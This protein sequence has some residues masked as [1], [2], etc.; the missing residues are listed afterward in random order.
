MGNQRDGPIAV[1]SNP[2]GVAI[3]PDGG[4]AY[5]ANIFGSSV[6]VIAIEVA[7][8]LTGTPASGV[9]GQ[10]YSHTFTTSGQPDPTITVTAGTL[11]AG[12]TRTPPTPNNTPRHQRVTP[13]AFPHPRTVNRSTRPIQLPPALPSNESPRRA[14]TITTANTE[15][16]H[17]QGRIT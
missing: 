6:S 1:G 15:K 5:V 9:L 13:P 16:R 7:P 10:P 2:Y 8:T 12:L 3:T 17:Q 11:P 4:R 14:T